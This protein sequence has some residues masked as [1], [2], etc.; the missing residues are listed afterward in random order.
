VVDGTPEERSKL[1]ESLSGLKD[2]EGKSIRG[3]AALSEG[4]RLLGQAV[5]VT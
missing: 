5:D 2:D 4:I 1:K 3:W